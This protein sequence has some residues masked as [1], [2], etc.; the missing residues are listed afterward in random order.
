MTRK[1]SNDMLRLMQDGTLTAADIRQIA[2]DTRFSQRASGKIDAADFFVNQ[3]MLA[4]EG[5][6]SFSDLAV[7]MELGT[8]V[9]ATRQAYWERLDEHCVRF[10]QAILERIMLARYKQAARAH[11]KPQGR[12]KRILIQDSTLIRLPMRLFPRFSG[13]RNA[14]TAVCNARIQ[15]I[16]DL[17]S[18]TFV[19]FSIDPYSRND[20]AATLDLVVQPGD[21]VL[22]DRGYFTVASAMAHRE[23]KAD[24][25]YRHKSKTALFDPET[26]APINLLRLL[27]R[28]GTLDMQV[29][30]GPE[31]KLKLRLV[32]ARVPEEVANLRRM[33]ARKEMKGHAPSADVLKLMSWNI[34]LTTLEE[35]AFTFQQIM[36]LYGLRWRIENIFKTWK[37][38]LG[39]TKIHN[40]SHN[41]LQVLLTARL[42]MII[43]L[44]HTLYLPLEAMVA[45]TSQRRLSLIRFIRH[46]SRNFTR[47]VAGIVKPC[48][49]TDDPLP[50]LL[51]H[52]TYDTRKRPNY[53]DK[54]NRVLAG[55][56]PIHV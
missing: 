51:R 3:C 14:D 54:M 47:F 34:F 23:G 6:A 5:T 22:R 8:G 36:E 15:G 16:Y 44:Y 26:G 7:R 43:L 35:S 18:G 50:F 20:L 27:N 55:L 19:H 24:S 25:I 42:I 2:R 30:V 48:S 4:V 10:F 38:H 33:K 41:Q 40:V 46:V 29:L 13:V 56:E 52:C 32:A 21:L 53:I 31:K 12:W 37:S 11:L 17:L 39:F 9:S 45:K 49:C 28:H 1:T